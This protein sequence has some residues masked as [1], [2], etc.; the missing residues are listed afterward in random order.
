METN[1]RI[2][3]L[4]KISQYILSL[5]LHHPVRVGVDGITASGKSSFVSELSD[6]LRLSHRK[7]IATTL[8]G[9][10]NP[11]IK[12]YERGRESAEGYYYDAYNY[13]EI[14]KQLLA[15]LG[16]G[17]SLLFKT[18]IFDLKTDEPIELKPS[19]M[20]VNS[21]LIV[22]GSFALRNELQQY[23][24]VGIYLKVDCHIAEER[25]ALRDSNDFGSFNEAKRITQ[26]RYHRAHKIHSEIAR[27]EDI[28]TFV[29]CNNNPMC[30]SILTSKYE[31]NS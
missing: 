11:R 4:N 2:E 10:H 30:A 17:G 18:Q 15:P 6:L 9:F 16:E 27:P 28:A 12:R 20:T 1:S 5:Q 29:I 7:V 13:N 26:V 8:D 3:V 22:D 23:W 25:A 19:K 24:D 21:V 14:I 31:M